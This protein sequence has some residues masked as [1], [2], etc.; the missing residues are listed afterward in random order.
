MKPNPRLFSLDHATGALA[1]VLDASID[2]SLEADLGGL[3]ARLLAREC[4]VAAPTSYDA[5]GPVL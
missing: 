3:A 5:Q 4:R 2:H 1:D